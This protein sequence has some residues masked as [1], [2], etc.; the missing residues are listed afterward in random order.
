MRRI[1]ERRQRQIAE[2]ARWI[3]AFDPD[4]LIV[5]Q[6][7]TLVGTYL[8][9]V[10]DEVDRARAVVLHRIGCASPGSVVVGE[11][12]DACTTA[13]LD[14]GEN[15]CAGQSLLQ[16]IHQINR[17]DSQLMQAPLARLMPSLNSG[18]VQTNAEAIVRI[19]AAARRTIVLGEWVELAI[20][21][22]WLAN[23]SCDGHRIYNA[24]NPGMKSTEIA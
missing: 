21:R 7:P 13:L 8:T 19:S 22:F 15:D 10:L 12:L 17:I 24:Q 23:R 4:A 18:V 1:P 2:V 11:A 9:C 3:V 20:L 14:H 6:D 5:V 16:R